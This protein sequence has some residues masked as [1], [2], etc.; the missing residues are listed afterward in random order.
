MALIRLM[1]GGTVGT[2]RTVTLAG[3]RRES[4]GGSNDNV[5]VAATTKRPGADYYRD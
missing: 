4:N 2:G 3:R 5:V 1:S